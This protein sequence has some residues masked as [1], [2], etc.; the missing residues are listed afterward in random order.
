MGSLALGE[1]IICFFLRS[2]KLVIFTPLSD[3]SL[4]WPLA[5]CAPAAGVVGVDWALGRSSDASESTLPSLKTE[6]SSREHSEVF[7]MREPDTSVDRIRS[8][9]AKHCFGCYK[10]FISG[11]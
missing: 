4:P 2:A 3:D 5:G 10:S 1:S 7:L 9:R 6:S 8:F 11:L